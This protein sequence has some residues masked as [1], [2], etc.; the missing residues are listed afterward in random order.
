MRRWSSLNKP[1]RGGEG[2]DHGGSKYLYWPTLSPSRAEFI[3][4]DINPP[5]RKGS[6]K[7][8][9]FSPV[10]HEI[11]RYLAA[12]ITAGLSFLSMVIVFAYLSGMNLPSPTA[13]GAGWT[14]LRKKGSRVA[15]DLWVA[16]DAL[17]FNDNALA[18]SCENLII[19]AGH[20]VTITGHLRDAG[21]DEN[22]W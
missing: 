8:R 9:R 22:D 1:V 17:P 21:V 16:E 14:G 5:R 18:R 19:V 2:K 13:G 3:P 6:V 11:D 10:V 4:S 15:H 7:D 20:S 12:Y